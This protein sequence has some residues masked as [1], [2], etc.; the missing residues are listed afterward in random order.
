M[1]NSVSSHSTNRAEQLQTG[2]KAN[3]KDSGLSMIIGAINW[4]RRRSSR[5]LHQGT[6]AERCFGRGGA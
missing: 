2:V 4:P 5:F 3:L 6:V 1:T